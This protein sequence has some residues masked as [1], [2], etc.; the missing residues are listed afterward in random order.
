ML[1]QD[2]LARA[3]GE[4]KPA[5]DS[6]TSPSVEC[7][8][9]EDKDCYMIRVPKRMPLAAFS[10]CKPREKNGVTTPNR[11]GY[12]K[13]NFPTMKVQAVGTGADGKESLL[14]FPTKA[15]NRFNLFVQLF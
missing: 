12:V 10:P 6:E 13:L 2:I 7:T 5:E 1:S 9:S 3:R 15:T 8:V 4:V 11:E 14:T